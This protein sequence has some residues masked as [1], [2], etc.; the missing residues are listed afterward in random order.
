MCFFTYILL[1]ST[2]TFP[3]KKSECILN[4]YNFTPGAFF[5]WLNGN[6]YFTAGKFFSQNFFNSLP[7]DWKIKNN[8]HFYPAM[9]YV[10]LLKKSGLLD[11]KIF[12]FQLFQK[13][14]LHIRFA[15]ALGIL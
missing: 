3:G 2:T 10:K 7:K 9:H 5:D 8:N 6:T 12:H 14:I 13:D 11:T 1:G 4:V 15:F